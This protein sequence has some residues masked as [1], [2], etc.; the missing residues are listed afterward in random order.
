MLLIAVTFC[1]FAVTFPAPPTFKGKALGTRLSQWKPP[2]TSQ[3]ARWKT[4]FLQMVTR[5]ATTKVQLQR[6]KKAEKSKSGNKDALEILASSWDGAFKNRKF[7]STFFLSL[8]LQSL[9]LDLIIYFS[10]NYLFF[11]VNYFVMSL[12]AITCNIHWFANFFKGWEPRLY[13]DGC[14]KA[15]RVIGCFQLRSTFLQMHSV[16]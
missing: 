3:I 4:V 11:S 6:T 12:K 9:F 5:T 8:I 13:C 2:P 14:P 15:L 10:Q 16:A 1:N 7:L